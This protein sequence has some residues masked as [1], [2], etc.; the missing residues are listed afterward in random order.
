LLELRDKSLR[1][2]SDVIAALNLPVLS[3]VP[4]V[5]NPPPGQNGNG[6]G[7]LSLKSRSGDR[8]DRVG[9]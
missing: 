3:Q 1:N 5:G 4:W 9:V 2:E 8:A 7:T 6:G